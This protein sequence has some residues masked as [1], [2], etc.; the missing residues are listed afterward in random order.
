[1]SPSFVNGKPMIARGTG[2]L[3]AA[4]GFGAKFA[5]YPV[6]RIISTFGPMQ[7]PTGGFGGGHGQMSH[8]ASSYAAV[9]SLA[10][11]GGGEVFQLIDR[12]AM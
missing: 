6:L 4:G 3:T 8:C 10:M 2:M 7:N 5:D 11:V 9:L 12:K 1:M